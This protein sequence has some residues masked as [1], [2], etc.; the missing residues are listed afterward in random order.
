[1][2]KTLLFGYGNPAR[3]DDGVAWHI[4]RL[5]SQRLGRPAPKDINDDF[6]STGA[7]PDLLF[8]LQLTPELAETVAE[9]DRVCFIDSHTQ[10]LPDDIMVGEITPLFQSSPFTHHMTPATCLSITESVYHHKPEALLV[11]VRGHCFGFSQSLSHQTEKLTNN[12]VELIWQWLN[13]TP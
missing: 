6:I 11:S 5:L 4:L 10:N 7:S 8:D 1:M 3:E 13:K 9:Y 12:A 2:N